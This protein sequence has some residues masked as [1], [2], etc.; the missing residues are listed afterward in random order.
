MWENEPAGTSLAAA[1]ARGGA[2]LWYSLEGGDGMFR[3]NP[4]AGLLATAAPLDYEAHNFYNLTVTAVNMVSSRTTP[5]TR[6]SLRRRRVILYPYDIRQG[7]GTARA[8]VSV[9]VLDRNEFPPRLVG[10]EFRGRVS[11]SAEAGAAVVTDGGEPLVLRTEDADGPANRQR[12]FEILEPDAAALFRLDPTTGALRTAARLDYE[13]AAEHRFTVRVSDAGSPRLSAHA[14]AAVVVRVL[15]VDDCAPTFERASYE[16]EVVTPTA[17]GVVVVTLLAA[18]PD[19]PPAGLQYDV[20][21]GDPGGAF[22]LS[23]RGVL[24]VARPAALS[25][26]HR[27]RVRV[28]D[29]LHSTTARVEVRV[30]DADNSGLAFQ[31]AEY[32]GSV[33]ENSTKP[34]TIAVLNV[35]GAAL[36]EHLDFRILNP[37]EGFEVSYT[38]RERRRGAKRIPSTKRRHVRRWG[39]RRAR[40]TRPGCRWTASC[41]TR[42]SCSWRRA[43]RGARAA[44]RAWLARAYTSPSPTSTT[45]V[46]YS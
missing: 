40:S 18:D 11:E 14:S 43:L 21:E 39:A 24:S 27:L 31:K 15:D 38:R 12:A 17:E 19:P 44:R 41:G 3:I 9:H 36:N 34:T 23:A 28:S 25:P 8:H 33:V 10:R 46:P 2:G 20:I 22:F 26:S 37:T 42:T 30:R 4:A 5:N 32:Y 16:A 35:L 45:T 6:V 7:G 1:E 13:H 29:G